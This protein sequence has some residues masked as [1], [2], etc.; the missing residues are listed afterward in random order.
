[1]KDNSLAI[2]YSLSIIV[3]Y[4]V[5]RLVLSQN[6]DIFVAMYFLI[7]IMLFENPKNTNNYFF[8]IGLFSGFLIGSKYAGPLFFAVLLL[9]YAKPLFKIISLKR[10]FIF[11]I[12]FSIFGLFWYSRNLV[13]TGSPFYPQTI[14]FFKG[15]TNWTSYLNV[16]IWGAIVK[17]PRL[18]LNAFVSEFTLW[19]GLFLAIPFFLVYL[20]I[21][22]KKYGLMPKLK[23]I[24]LICILS[25]L[26]YI[27]L[28]YDK[29]YLGMVL[30]IR[31]IYS[32]FTLLALSVFLIAQYFKVEKI[33]S[34]TLFFTS[35]IIFSQ[36]YHPKIVYIYS[37]II[38]LVLYLFIYRKKL[39]KTLTK[40]LPL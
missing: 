32:V 40:H 24:L 37:P 19:P 33:L 35:L 18:M 23:R 34:I 2:I 29:L 28:P 21:R 14:L 12:P 6:V 8:T 15:L 3:S 31:Y 17:T 30:S 36:P 11:L 5:F 27:F 4:G 13:L 25:L 16:P 38:F 26:I 22:Q 7:L 1:M 39:V 20:K 9:I 10:L